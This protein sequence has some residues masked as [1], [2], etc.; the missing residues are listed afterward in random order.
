M[1]PMM[2]PLRRAR[3][4]RSELGA[5]AETMSIKV[6]H[7]LLIAGVAT[8]GVSGCQR[9]GTRAAR[10]QRTTSAAESHAHAPLTV[11]SATSAV[12][13]GARRAHAPLGL[14]GLFFRAARATGLNG[15]AEATIV[16]LEGQLE[17]AY[18]L[19]NT[20]ARA[21][22]SDLAF[23]IRGRSMNTAKL[24][25]DED[26]FARSLTALTETQG[27]VFRVLHDVLSDEQRGSVASSIRASMSRSEQATGQFR[28]QR[29][30]EQKPDTAAKLAR[31]L[32]QMKAQLTL[33]AEQEKQV[34]LLLAG[35]KLLNPPSQAALRDEAAK[36]QMHDLLAAFESPVFDST[37]VN[38]APIADDPVGGLEQQV[39]LIA[40]I[41]PLLKQDQ[42]RLLADAVA[43]PQSGAP[44]L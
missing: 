38:L 4:H 1:H 29:S 11:A 35:M 10:T 34:A 22:Q 3:E 17:K 12:A 19:P 13:S 6:A 41:V 44:T 30:G 23:S 7:L 18:E 32:Q 28:Q 15:S 36:A 39:R 43:P 27:D 14:A 20:A 33:D 37:K 31:R 9:S 25:A 21:F 2:P 24:V 8:V 5:G 26:R 42:V 16:S 40:G